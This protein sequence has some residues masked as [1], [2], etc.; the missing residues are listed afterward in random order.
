MRGFDVLNHQ[1]VNHYHSEY[2]TSKIHKDLKEQ[3]LIK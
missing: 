3:G 2:Y 1:Y